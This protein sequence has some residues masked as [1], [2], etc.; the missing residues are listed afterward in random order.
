QQ[1][2]PQPSE[3]VEDAR[4]DRFFD[5][6]EPGVQLLFQALDER[7][8]L[9]PDGHTGVAQ[10]IEVLRQLRHQLVP[11]LRRR[12]ADLAEV[13]VEGG[14]VVHYGSLPRSMIFC[15]SCLVAANA[16]ACWCRYT[17]P[18]MLSVSPIRPVIAQPS[19]AEASI[20][21]SSW[22]YVTMLYLN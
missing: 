9:L 8:D 21:D 19:W 20:L 7:L 17:I 12:P 1:L 5:L 3:V 18:V 22:A 11:L 15:R 16:L 10:R 4:P 14:Y 2:L 6:V 13:L